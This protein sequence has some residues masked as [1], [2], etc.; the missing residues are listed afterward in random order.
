MQPA[1]LRA[2]FEAAARAGR[3]DASTAEGVGDL[4]GSLGRSM[5]TFSNGQVGSDSLTAWLSGTADFLSHS[6][7]FILTGSDAAN[8]AHPLWSRFSLQLTPPAPAPGA[9]R[10]LGDGFP[11]FPKSWATEGPSGGLG[12]VDSVIAPLEVSEPLLTAANNPGNDV[13]APRFTG[14]LILAGGKL[15]PYQRYFGSG[16]LPIDGTAVFTPAA[17][18][19]LP[20]LRLVAAGTSTISAGG[21]KLGPLGIQLRTDWQNKV[22]DLD[23]PPRLSAALAYCKTALAD[24]PVEAELTA[25]LLSGDYLWTMIADFGTGLGL[26]EGMQLI[27]S[28]F[29]LAGDAPPIAKFS[30]PAG[31]SPIGDFKLRQV[32]FGIKPPELPGNS[33]AFVH[34]AVD[35]VS[36]TPWDTPLAFLRIEEVGVRWLYFVGS[37]LP[38]PLGSIWG[39]LTLGSKKQGSTGAQPTNTPIVPASDVPAIR[40]NVALPSLAVSAA[41][42]EPL[43]INLGKFFGYYFPGQPANIGNSDRPLTIESFE[44]VAS[45]S[46]KHYLAAIEI[47][48]VWS[49][50]AGPI[51][52]SLDQL[53][54]QVETA[55][56]TL[57]GEL[58]AVASV[59]IPDN[60][61]AAVRMLALASYPGDGH[62]E[63][64]ARLADTLHVK[65]FVAA[66]T[67]ST[68]PQW[69]R[70]MPAIDIVGLDA[71]YSTADGKPY[72]IS[73][74][75]QVAWQQTILGSPLKIAFAG[76][77]ERRV[78]GLAHRDRALAL[79][80]G[81]IQD[82]VATVTEGSLNFALTINRFEVTGSITF[83]DALK[84]YTFSISWDNVKLIAATQMEKDDTG[85]LSHQVLAVRL[86]GVTLGGIVEYF[87]NLANP[88]ANFRLDPPW[89]FLN[90]IDLA[91]FTLILDKQMQR[92]RLTYA[93]DINLAFASIT[94][95]GLVYDR[96]GGEGSVRFVVEGSML[97]KP[98]RGKDALQW[99]AVKDNPPAVPGKG[100]ALFSLHYLGAGQHVT[101]KSLGDKIASISTVIDALVADMKPVDDPAQLPVGAD[102]KIH[103]DAASQWMLGLDCTFMDTVTLKLVLH[104]PD[105][106]GVLIALK[107]EQAKSLAGFTFELFYRKV[108]ADVGV[109]HARLQVP[110]AFRQ[111]QFGAVSV[112]LGIITLDIFTNGNFRIDLGFPHNRDFADSFAVEAGPFNGHGGLYFG[113][114]DGATSDRV[115]RVVNGTFSPVLELGVGLMV[116]LGRDFKKGPL[117]AG[118]YVDMVVIFEGV[119]GWFHPSD[120]GAST[121]LYYWAQGTAGIVGK[122]YG[123]VDFKII[124]V[125][126]SVEA[127]AFAT[128]TLEAHQPTE[129][130]LDVEVE[131]EATVHFLFFSVDFSFGLHLTTSF[132]IGEA[133]ATPWQ[134][135]TGASV[136]GRRQLAFHAHSP[137]RRRHAVA[138]LQ[139]RRI[140]REARAGGRSEAALASGVAPSPAADPWHLHFDKDAKVF[141]LGEKKSVQLKVLPVFTIADLPVDWTPDPGSD[142]APDYRIAFLLSAETAVP[143]GATSLAET[144]V[145][146]VAASAHA[147]TP[148][149]MPF[150][151]LVEAVFRWTLDAAGIKPS[152]AGEGGGGG[153]TLGMLEDVVEQLDMPQ[154]WSQGFT[155]ANLEGFLTGNLEMILSG[156]PAGP[157]P[158]PIAS[159]PFPM[160][161]AL[162]WKWDDPSGVSQIRDFARWCMVDSDY[163]RRILDYFK[164]LDPRPASARPDSAARRQASA[165]EAE[166]PIASFIFRD[167]FLMLARASV[168]AA[169]DY[170]TAFPHPVAAT[171]SLASIAAQ[172]P[173]FHV[174]L[175]G[176]ED[177]SID[178]I[179]A[180]YG[181]SAAEFLALNPGFEVPPPG[182]T[183]LV[184]LGVSV[185][186]VAES[187]AS[188]PVTRG[189]TVPIG[190]LVDEVREGDTLAIVA[191]RWS[192][193]STEIWLKS[194][195]LLGAKGLLRA[196]ASLP[197][198][199]APYDNPTKLGVDYAAAVLF[200]R[201]MR[202][203]A[204]V[205]PADAD[206]EAPLAD[207]YAG[208]IPAMQPGGAG[209]YQADG[210]LKASF[211]VPDRAFDTSRSISWNTLPGDTLAGVATAV[212]LAQNV[213]PGSAFKLWLDAVEAANP[214]TLPAIALPPS[215]VALV[216][217]G[218]TI[219]QLAARLF[220]DGDAV[221]TLALHVSGLL[222]PLADIPVTGAQ[223]KT[224]P[225]VDPPIAG[226]GLLATAQAF[227]L[228]LE[229]F[230]A[231]VSSQR[232]L[233]DVRG[234]P[235]PKPETPAILTVRN[236]PVLALE[237]LVPKLHEPV[238]AAAISGQVSRFMLNGLRLPE[239]HPVVPGTVKGLYDLAGQQLPG[240]APAGLPPDTERLT[241][242]MIAG[243]PVPWLKFA[244]SLTSTAGGTLADAV[245]R[246]PGFLAMNPAAAARAD[247]DTGLLP[248]GMI[249]ITAAASS[250]QVRVTEGDLAL[251]YP[252]ATLS[253][254]LHGLGLQALPLSRLVEIRHPIGQQT[255]WR[256]TVAP[257]LPT[258]PAPG[259]TPSLWLLPSDLIKAAAPGVSAHPYKLA[260][261]V[262][263]SG[264]SAEPHDVDSWAWATLID[265]AV[266]R[267][268][269]AAG[270]LEVHGAD[271][272]DRLR[273]ADLIARLTAADVFPGTGA[274]LSL[275]W[276]LPPGPGAPGGITTSAADPAKS[277]LIKTNLSTETH[278]GSSNAAVVPGE[279]IY[280]ASFA[281]PELRPLLTLFWE[282][283][284]VG[285]GG[286]WLQLADAQ[287]NPLLPEAVFDQDGRAA[288]TL[289]VQLESQC[290]GTAPDRRLYSF[291]NAAI[292]GDGLD[293]GSVSLYA[294]AADG[295]ETIR[296]ATARPGEIG[297]TLDLEKPIRPA[298][299]TAELRGRRLY[300]LLGYELLLPSGKSNEG[301]PLAPQV[302]RGEDGEPIDNVWHLM[303]V[304]PINRFGVSMLPAASVLPDPKEDPYAGVNAPA[305]AP[306][307]SKA[308]ASLWFHDILG[309]RT[310]RDSRRQLELPITYTDPLL[311]PDSWPL[312]TAS[313]EIGADP[314]GAV[315]LHATV[316]FQG[317]A[318]QPGGIESGAAA[319]ARAEQQSGRF[320][321]VWYQILQPDVTAS[322]STTIRRDSEKA[323][324]PVAV[325]MT[326]LRTYA[327]GAYV[328][329]CT[330]SKL[331]SAVALAS[332][333]TSGLTAASVTAAYGV[334]Y[335]ALG[336]ANAEQIVRQLFGA[337]SVAVPR[338]VPA[339]P[340][341][342][343]SQQCPA[344]TD[345][346][347]VLS[348][349]LN[350][351]LPLQPGAVLKSPKR[352]LR[353][354]AAAG[355]ETPALS[356][357]LADMQGTIDDFAANNAGVAFLLEPGAV[358]SY[359]G[360][361]VAVALQ[362][363]EAGA[364]LNGIKDQMIAEGAAAAT[365]VA[366]I[367]RANGETPGLLRPDAPLELTCYVAARD[368]T[369]AVNGSGATLAALAKANVDTVGLYP[370][371]TPLLLGTDPLATPETT[372]AEFERQQRIGPGDLF[373]FNPA[374][375]LMDG[376]VILPGRYLWPAAASGDLR[377]PLTVKAGATLASLAARLL[378][379]AP[380]TPA[381]IDLAEMNRAMP[382]TVSADLTLTVDGVAVATKAGDSFDSVATR[383][384][385]TIA[386]LARAIATDGRVLAPGALLVAPPAI[387]L[388]P[389]SGKVSALTPAQAAQ[390]FG[391]SPAALLAANAGMPGLLVPG[392]AIAAAPKSA[393]TET[394]APN[395]TLSSLLHRF[396]HRGVDSSIE[397]LAAAN[398]AVA[399]LAVGALALLAPADARLD[400]ALG[401]A[402]E[403]CYP[404]P[405]FPIHSWLRLKRAADLCD[406]ILA[407]DP[408]SNVVS[409]AAELPP[410]R[411][412]APEGARDP[413]PATLVPFADS[414]E[415]AVPELRVATGRTEKTDGRA[416]LWAVVFGPEGIGRV[417]VPVP[418]QGAGEDERQPRIFA[419]RPLANSLV[420]RRGVDIAGFDSTTGTLTATKEKR[421]F[422]GIDLEV[423]AT[424]FLADV[425]R[426]LSSGLSP[427]AYAVNSAALD[428][429]AK[430]KK[431]VADAAAKG[432][433]PVLV[434]GDGEGLGQAVAA[435]R[436]TLLGSLTAG[437]ATSA[438]LQYDSVIEAVDGLA[439]ARLSGVARIDTGG[440]APT[441]PTPTISNAKISLAKAKEL[442]S[443]RVNFL[444]TV[445]DVG[446]AQ[447]ISVKLDYSF[448]ELEFAIEP[449]LEG[450]EKSQWLA[451]VNPLR[452]GHPA[453]L[454]VQL[455]TPI[456]P[457]PLRAYPPMPILLDQRAAATTL[458]PQS[459]SEAV[460]WD[461]H[462]RFQHQ[463]AA[464]D[465]IDLR[466]ELNSRKPSSRLAVDPPED[467]FGAL[468]QY[469]AIADPLWALL[470]SLAD[471]KTIADRVPV[472]G[473][474]ATF[475]TLAEKIGRLW[476][477]HWT[478]GAD[479]GEDARAAATVPALAA[480]TLGF[481]VRMK[482]DADPLDH[483]QSV[484]LT[485]DAAG[486]TLEW[487]D[488][489]CSDAGGE[490]VALLRQPAD[491]RHPDTGVYLF[492]KGS[493]VPAHVL[494]SWEFV[495]RRLHIATFQDAVAKVSVDRNVGL[496]PEKTT[497]PDFVYQ[498]PMTSYA[499]PVV[500]FISVSDT[501]DLGP[502]LA[503]SLSALFATVFDGH[504]IG[505]TVALGVRYAYRLTHGDPPIETELAVLQSP[506][507]PYVPTSPTDPAVGTIPALMTAVAAWESRERPTVVGGRWILSIDL[508]ST[509]E[510]EMVRPVLQLKRLSAP[511]G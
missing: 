184:K 498:T 16:P 80:S 23:A 502:W 350:R 420:S 224:A 14:L 109:F 17:P 115:P 8:P 156:T 423:W 139:S 378:F 71:R 432:L 300:S 278:S 47:G 379:P 128:V 250:A 211:L 446:E 33:F 95:V 342:S 43:P 259:A 341:K 404:E 333:V 279:E 54:F 320:A 503:P 437:Y 322:L 79:T 407:A 396:Q 225:I 455:G 9:A 367:L 482:L 376:V 24:L 344:G 398:Q 508:H 506:S 286:Y 25:P 271:T 62:W 189:L 55:S 226:P 337:G 358:F 293:P 325:P 436:Q 273:L 462:F 42:E 467:L 201:G 374:A 459:I 336:A 471:P 11:A 451:F 232:E 487:P 146:H 497:A 21:L 235:R 353:V 416:E 98:Y 113:L 242:A 247:P 135:A 368:D 349:A 172:F 91:R 204:S 111:L 391:V 359:N 51:L 399:F 465:G 296:R 207:W 440:T 303:R 355:G 260:Q 246:Y 3:L 425:E 409:A 67:G 397:L 274:R 196:G 203:P 85:P 509:L 319:A 30:L 241:L 357:L 310:G 491:P 162:R 182:K 452:S 29:A 34:I 330:L 412:N 112:T 160:I 105:L 147:E 263:Q 377:I 150:S 275:G 386:D 317:G 99:D 476:A 321:N 308:T 127:K 311:A 154:A 234:P 236:V 380:G 168:Q 365:T 434:G 176:A 239:P 360:F 291:N 361:V 363:P 405:I 76:M 327:A 7:S 314:A 118:L 352:S 93:V 87:V 200:A 372:L 230:A 193:A 461:Y 132:T 175:T 346:E 38:L 444:L 37:G 159:A 312:T 148:S 426:L 469:G 223:I 231:R 254:G 439:N 129:V 338:F 137:V 448:T 48:N 233:L 496:L 472:S 334:D 197:V 381:H 290:R 438:L 419:L 149:D 427:G 88:N 151:R 511:I 460:H 445:P 394:I 50:Q 15:E 494:H 108:S 32:E 339:D 6:W 70:D 185:E 481:N 214:K 166:E 500:P 406:P 255:R 122:L 422:Q 428:K 171:D 507:V 173:T 245:A 489:Y 138:R 40:V 347:T 240:P 375:P 326:A 136:R 116:G 77:V 356:R 272:A 387:L 348:S 343:V 464:Q 313:F 104:D 499:A 238:P 265:V 442:P 454:K 282:C 183:R 1:D 195:S 206:E 164:K 243:E 133:S 287:G 307:P 45:V 97:G 2:A 417:E 281:G 191:G 256:T 433:A 237:T 157:A 415:K 299:D 83:A 35:I 253:P 190:D 486:A 470:G 388:A 75:L 261:I 82:D 81:D 473:A 158:D 298:V 306:R 395:D 457:L 280:F 114:L 165:G 216:R 385:K 227:G 141:P 252:A 144:R 56:S 78:A 466:L 102:R 268:P 180:G 107:G 430:A 64:E 53:S 222:V 192:L 248:K 217:P 74:Q 490:P 474:L 72:K 178:S 103:F 10:R 4:L 60:P 447:S 174:D 292:I 479:A 249:L 315:I 450:F 401:D 297:F 392:V 484:T 46:D 19:E 63:F 251:N 443:G 458:H 69:V 309:N 31:L 57:S 505:R 65:D 493:A 198:T 463:S 324:V 370:A 468:A 228:P 318:L 123:S 402:A 332:E 478:P 283:S 495:Y 210:T 26:S 161:P 413:G 5:L 155:A 187:A 124:S 384:G 44:I 411:V 276:T 510:P 323:P 269:G 485:R 130:E 270:T 305:A 258:A 294:T 418:L 366:D 186:A 477:L 288:I 229:D 285:G 134:L 414:L 73:G 488:L 86:E 295:L 400:G 421:D 480:P 140:Y 449:S 194:E 340:T 424:A 208:A 345:A 167:Y 142:D 504:P 39:K 181:L 441:K 431:A 106:Y 453:A 66:F 267:I 12:L 188:W 169:A 277:F 393:A 373:A 262:A 96:K 94:S 27:S 304:V 316:R 22:P 429:L 213:V 354:P 301:Q 475:A 202:M 13:P 58:M 329:A 483:E 221:A 362:G 244:E 49:I 456:V 435:L 371:G 219:G 61:G 331:S 177:D 179:A 264:P 163:E 36:A 126:V 199:A 390:P 18:D 383:A 266:H 125:S 170:L 145:R 143:P 68:P 153:V 328:L 28:I 369:F 41:L 131:V 100:D 209:I 92:I 119:L 101:P 212:S 408:A 117:S 218:D 215:A 351:V 389:G 382:A 492:P 84:T 501:L 302:K 257:M 152:L 52:F 120:S 90:S 410:A 284:V 121:S 403:L 110:D 220:M 335:D 364:T 59:A 289:I 205:P 89:D 20:A